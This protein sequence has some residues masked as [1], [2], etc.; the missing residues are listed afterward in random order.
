MSFA[1]R[2]QGDGPAFLAILLVGALTAIGATVTDMKL[3]PPLWAHALIWIPF[4]FIGSILSLRWIK[5]WMIA[6]QYHYRNDDFTPGP[7]A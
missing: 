6:V 2:E 1:G 5:A 7:E 3:E 4:V